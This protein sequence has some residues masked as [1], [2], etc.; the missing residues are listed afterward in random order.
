LKRGYCPIG[1]IFKNWPDIAVPSH[2]PEQ[3]NLNKPP[4]YHIKE[5]FMA[6]KYKR[7]YKKPRDANRILKDKDLLISARA[8]P[9]LK[10]FLNR[11]LQ[12]CD[13]ELIL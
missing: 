10:A 1:Q 6:G 3:V 12:L 13:G 9:E 4:S 11:I 7:R 2:H 5:M 8:C